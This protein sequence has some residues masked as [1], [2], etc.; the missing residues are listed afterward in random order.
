MSSVE[1]S[2]RTPSI[3]TA[4]IPVLKPTRRFQVAGIL[5]E[6][7]V[8][9]PIPMG[10]CPPAT[11]TAAPAE[12]PPGTRGDIGHR[13]V[14]WRTEVRIR[15][16]AAKRELDGQR[17]ADADETRLSA[18]ADDFRV[19]RRRPTRQLRGT[20]LREHTGR[21]EEVLPRDWH[22]IQRA[23]PEAGGGA[24]RGGGRLGAST[25]RREPDKAGGFEAGFFNP[26]KA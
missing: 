6:P 22:T 18:A 5:T 15:A 2:G 25:V 16:D 24:V 1:D 3:G 13:S 19:K 17:L 14:G 4:P 26:G 9:L 12:E 23:P 21:V 11:E 7:P 8:S 10:T 20:A